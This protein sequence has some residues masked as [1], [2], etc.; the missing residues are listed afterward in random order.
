MAHSVST[1]TDAREGTIPH[2]VQVE[3]LAASKQLTPDKSLNADLTSCAAIPS[4]LS[5]AL[6]HASSARGTQ[7]PHT[8][9]T[10]LDL[11]S[12]VAG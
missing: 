11:G 3:Q 7:A 4:P 12:S 5:L 2:D 6:P 10:S 8:T 9:R 1:T